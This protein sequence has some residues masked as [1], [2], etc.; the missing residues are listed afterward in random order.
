[1]KDLGGKGAGCWGSGPFLQHCFKHYSLTKLL[2]ILYLFVDYICYFSKVKLK[3]KN[4]IIQAK[5]I[6]YTFHPKAFPNQKLETVFM[7]R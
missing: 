7:H 5:I 6:A 4:S 2:K 3:S 1:M